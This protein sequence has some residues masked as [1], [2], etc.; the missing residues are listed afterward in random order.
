MDCKLCKLPTPV[1]P[2]KNGDHVFCCIGCREVYK[3]FGEDVF[4]TRSQKSTMVE[5]LLPEGKEAFFKIDGMHCSSC[6]ILI[7]RIAG[8]IDG[9]LSAASNYATST[10]KIVFDPAVI[11]E[12]RLAESLSITG[13]TARS[14]S[15]TEPPDDDERALLR[16][17]TATSLSAVVMMLYLAF[18]YPTNLGLV[19]VNDLKPVSWL[20]FR[21]APNA[22]FVLTTILVF[23]VAAPI[24]RGALIG[25][26]TG[27]LN[28]DNLLAIAILSSYGYSV[29]QWYV[30]SHDLYFDVTAA[31]VTVVTYGRFFERGARAKATTEL[32]NLMQAWTPI[33]RIKE[34]GTFK[35]CS[36]DELKPGTHVFVRQNEPVPV[37]GIVVE[38]QAAIDESL[39]TGEP[40]PVTRSIGEKVY[41]GAVVVEGDIEIRAGDEIESQ[42]DVL[43]HI[44]WNIQSSSTGMRG[45]ADRLARVFVPVVLLL[46]VLVTGGSLLAGLPVQAALLSGLATLIVSC[47]CTFGLAIPLASAAGVSTALRSGIIITSADVFEKP[48]QFDT[49]AIDKTG[50]LST[51]GMSVQEV[52]GDEQTIAYAAAVERLSNHPIA[53]AIARLDQKLTASGLAIHPGRGAVAMVEGRKVAVGSKQLFAILQWEIDPEIAT[54]ATKTVNDSG[55]GKNVISYVGWDGRAH[56]AVITRDKPRPE[57]QTIVERLQKTSRV[58]LLSGAELARDYQDHLDEVYTSVPP[59]AKAAVIRG[60]GAKGTVAMIGDGSNDAP[61][62]AAA[63]LG[64][65]FGSPTVLAADAADVIIPGDQ[66]EKVFDAFEIIS[67]TRTRIRQNLC[68]ALL[69]NA[70]AIPLALTGY[71]NPLFAALAMSSSSLLVVWNSSRSIKNVTTP[72]P[73]AESGA[74]IH[75]RVR[76]RSVKI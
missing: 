16:V 19:D 72:I 46:A 12:T 6:E 40:F 25:L 60:L 68:W 11:D 57:W 14:R 54:S 30:G 63:D 43:A 37:D 18:F 58:V 39:M 13:Y 53:E 17:I 73:L 42:M 32:A 49:V 67:T 65:A 51:G 1:P 20:A 35:Q 71:I 4:A 26:R 34:N 55:K 3:H 36:I 5:P 75:N 61:A 59:E 62:L 28:M 50:T 41:G 23:Y 38:G 22:M 31:I 45:L 70:I 7:E 21:A 74:N 8:R 15:D 24:F 76:M 9:V 48:E 44:L 10:A 64:I 33:A 2:I 27:I 52:I 56:G 29:S 66:L 47:P 69:Y